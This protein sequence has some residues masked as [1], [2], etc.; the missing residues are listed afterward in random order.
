MK[1]RENDKTKGLSMCDQ[2]GYQLLVHT[3]KSS[4]FVEVLI[5]FAL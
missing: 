2:M 3:F 5:V 1:I 4:N